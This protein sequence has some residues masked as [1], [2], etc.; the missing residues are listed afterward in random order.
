MYEWNEQEQMI[1]SAIRSF[2]DAE[3]R[4]HVDEL[5]FGDMPPYDLLRKMFNTFG[6]G[7]MAKA[8]FDK[9]IEK[10]R[11]REAGEG[12]DEPEAVDT[13]GGGDLDQAVMGLMLTTELCRVVPGFVGAMGVS[14]GLA[15]GT[16]Q[17]R[18]TIEQQERWV[19]D[20]LTFD[21]V[22]AWAITEPNSGSDAFGGMVTT[23]RKEGEGYVIN[24]N[25]TFITNGPFAD[26]IVFYAKLDNGAPMRDRP[27][28]T[29][30]LDA[31][32]EGLERSRPMRKMGFHSSPTGELF[33]SD[34]YA[35]PERLLGGE[36]DA[37]T[38]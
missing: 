1:Q 14:V 38:G 23:A 9:R 12:G 7:P 25:K 10:L 28:L 5:E 36:T 27:I 8:A 24:G 2:I 18:G 21:K 34:V 11:A 31:D 16:I 30:V 20:L 33:L 3:I 37:N 15:A 29:F 17:A 22:G 4:P 26:T 13:I 19:P 6:I 35:G 32:M